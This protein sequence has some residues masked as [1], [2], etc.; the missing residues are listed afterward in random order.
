MPCLLPMPII[1][2]IIRVPI[3]GVNALMAVVIAL[4]AV[5]VV[6]KVVAVVVRV[7]AGVVARDAAA[8]VTVVVVANR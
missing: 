4:V 8:V 6:R 5:N 2:A 7:R 1:D 3:N